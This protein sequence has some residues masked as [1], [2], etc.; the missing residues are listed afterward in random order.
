MIESVRYITHGMILDKLLRSLSLLALSSICPGRQW[1]FLKELE[2]T[3]W[4]ILRGICMCCVSNYVNSTDKL[5]CSLVH[6]IVCAHVILAFVIYNWA[7]LL[8]FLHRISSKKFEVT[9][10]LGWEDD[11]EPV[12]FQTLSDYLVS[13]KQNFVEFLLKTQARNGCF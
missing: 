12:K 9:A 13:W 1:G 3:D 8:Y 2:K 5:F 11:S 10:K 4:S 6:R 7:L